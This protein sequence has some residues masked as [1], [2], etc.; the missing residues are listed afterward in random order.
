MENFGWL[1]NAVC[2]W[3][4]VTDWEQLPQSE[5]FMRMAFFTGVTVMASILGLVLGI[6]DWRETPLAKALGLKRSQRTP[7]WVKRANALAGGAC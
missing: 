2:G 4:G 5:S 3:F 6:L 1:H 7:N